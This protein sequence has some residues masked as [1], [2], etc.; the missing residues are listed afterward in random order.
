MTSASQLAMGGTLNPAV[1]AVIV[2]R[3]WPNTDSGVH[4]GYLIGWS[5]PTATWPSTR[6]LQRHYQPS[7]RTAQIPM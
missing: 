1:S 3:Y 4:V 2:T 6:A 5:D 7:F